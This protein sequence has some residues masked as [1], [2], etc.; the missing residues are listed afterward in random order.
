MKLKK[1][2]KIKELVFVAVAITLEGGQLFGLEVP[3][4]VRLGK[5]FILHLDNLL[6]Q[7]L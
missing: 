5:Y 6:C 4:P 1:V 2:D 7:I 3:R